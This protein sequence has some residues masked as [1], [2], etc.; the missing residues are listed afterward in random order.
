MNTEG[1]DEILK[2]RK[3]APFVGELP[4][5]AIE[6]AQQDTLT[7]HGSSRFLEYRRCQRAHSLRYRE[8][9]A[10]VERLFDRIDYF[11]LGSTIH[12]C[13][14]YAWEGF[15]IGEPREWRH[16]LFAATLRG[17]LDEDVFEE[18]DRLCSAYFAHYG[19]PDLGFTIL[20]VETLLEDPASFALPY[21][22]RLDLIGEAA[23]EIVIVDTKTRAKK[24]PDDRI[25]YARDL[26][27][28]AQFLGQ[29][30]LAM[31]RYG[32]KE[33]PPI[34]VNAIIKTKIPGFDRLTVRPSLAD[35]ERWRAQQ[36]RDASWGLEGTEM[37]YSSC[38]PELGSRCSYFR[39]C[40][41][42]DEERSRHFKKAEQAT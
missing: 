33:P 28:R 25:T 35:V 26:T 10:P 15:R 24:I 32:L 8:R 23:G 20:G 4:A 3:A 16:A 21:T 34:I 12:A 18:A 19:E 5:A 7:S 31:L 40:H 42:S 14:A 2:S 38:A 13:L 41:G 11:S 29:A 22:A 39:W 1:W 27:T 17:D 30:H 6:A 36:R 9:I 37:N